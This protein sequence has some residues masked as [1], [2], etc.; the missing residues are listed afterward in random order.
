M[1]RLILIFVFAS[2]LVFANSIILYS[3]PVTWFRTWGIPNRVEDGKRIV[4][5]F[6]GGYAVLNI[7]SYGGGNDYFCLLKYNYLGNFL[8]SK[9]IID[10]SSR[11]L[12]DMQQTSDSGFIFAGYTSGSLLVKTDK[13]GNLKWLRNYANLNP[14]TRFYSVKQTKDNG[15][16]ACGDF[17]DYA[18]PSNKAILIKVDSLGYTQWE[19][20]YIDS[21]FTGYGDVIQGI[22]RKFYVTGSTGNGYPSVS[23][24]LVKK[25]DSLGNVIWMN[26][27]Y[28]NGGGQDITQ[29]RD[30]S[31]VVGGKG[32]ISTNRPI[33]AKFDTS[34]NTKWVR[35]YYPTPYLWY[36]YMTK[37]LY[38]NLIITGLYQKGGYNE[39]IGIW[40]LD[41]S[42]NIIK[43]KEL[44][45]SGYSSIYSSCIK[46]TSDS[47]FIIS[48]NVFF[49]SINSGDAL[50]IKTDS[51]FNTPIITGIKNINHQI[52]NEFKVNH[53]FPNPFNSTT[54]IKFSLPNNGYVNINICDILGKDVY[55]KNEFRIKGF[56][57]IK[58]DFYELNLSSGIYFIRINF[59]T[60][61]KLIKAIFLK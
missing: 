42:G 31:L 16:I 13:N 21:L 47:G 55:S 15:Y 57:D 2:I 19:K 12:I 28:A 7:V 41:T 34:G 36:Y 59:E 27:F 60:Q 29:L 39:T 37:D 58:F 52:S 18:N 61:S 40:K 56:N 32:S 49:S 45:F 9:I 14:E 33:L 22:D 23:Y 11:M 35:Y 50:I 53:N 24:A 44:S 54:L 17:T 5:T 20:Q 6:D 26:I 4:Q 46:P 38:D 10:T 48:G 51:A 25:I 3:Q 30:G 8:W 43:T 1:R